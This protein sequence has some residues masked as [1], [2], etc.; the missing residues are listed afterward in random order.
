MTSIINCPFYKSACK[1]T[2]CNGETEFFADSGKMQC[3][4]Y[5]DYEPSLY[6]TDQMPPPKPPVRINKNLALRVQ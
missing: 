3:S 2:T 1:E 4:F 6:R 5:D